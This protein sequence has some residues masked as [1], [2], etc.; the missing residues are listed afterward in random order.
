MRPPFQPSKTEKRIAIGL[1]LVS[2]VPFVFAPKPI[3]LLVLAFQGSFL[4]AMLIPAGFRAAWPLIGVSILLQV[5][6]MAQAVR[7]IAEPISDPSLVSMR[8]AFIIFHCLVLA[9]LAAQLVLL[10]R[11]L[12]RQPS[13]PHPPDVL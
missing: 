9:Y 1:A 10:L 13:L 2:L 11:R 12:R 3:M 4:L 6:A 7:A 8:W 5:A